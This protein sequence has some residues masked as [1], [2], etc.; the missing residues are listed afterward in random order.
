MKPQPPKISQA[1]GF[2]LR[3]LNLAAR[4]WQYAWPEVYNLKAVQLLGI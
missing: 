2:V 4:F 1:K 3:K